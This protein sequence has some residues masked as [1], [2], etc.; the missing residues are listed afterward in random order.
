MYNKLKILWRC[1]GFQIF[2]P[3]IKYQKRK[4]IFGYRLMAHSQKEDMAHSPNV[5]NKTSDI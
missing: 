5:R 4:L 1:D 3:G 2:F